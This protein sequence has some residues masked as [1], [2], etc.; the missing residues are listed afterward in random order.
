MNSFPNSERFWQY[1]CTYQYSVTVKMGE[2]HL[3]HGAVDLPDD[4]CT[5]LVN[6]T[7]RWMSVGALEPVHLVQ[8][9]VA[10]VLEAELAHP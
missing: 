7:A 4:M 2:T 6:L 9:G 1:N 8:I 3:L 10:H 5:A